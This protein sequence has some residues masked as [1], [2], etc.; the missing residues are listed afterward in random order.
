MKNMELTIRE[1]F[2][3]YIKEKNISCSIEEKDIWSIYFF[4]VYVRFP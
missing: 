4:K 1:I 2:D 3:I